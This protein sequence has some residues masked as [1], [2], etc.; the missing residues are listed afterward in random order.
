MQ[1]QLVV[2]PTIF[3]DTRAT[4]WTRS[5]II[6]GP[7]NRRRCPGR[8]AVQ[9]KSFY[10]FFIPFCKPH[11]RSSDSKALTNI[12]NYLSGIS[13]MRMIPSLLRVCRGHSRNR[14]CLYGIKHF[15]LNN[16]FRSS[17]RACFYTWHAYILYQHA[18]MFLATT[19]YIC[20]IVNVRV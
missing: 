16:F 20:R 15:F 3:C 17:L 13:F 6:K 5:T 8:N 10:Y 12:R 4:K 7:E 9:G 1:V 2:V 11:I 18:H 19:K 14:K